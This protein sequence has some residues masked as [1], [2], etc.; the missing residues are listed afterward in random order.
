MRTPEVRTPDPTAVF[1]MFHYIRHN[2]R[3]QEHLA[4]LGLDLAQRRVL[5]LGAGIGDH[6]TFFLDRG[7][8][9]VAVEPR[10]ENVAFFRA[11]IASARY[12]GEVPLTI[13]AMDVE[14]AAKKLRS[15]RFDV[16]Y[17]YGLLYHVPDPLP[18][19]EFAREVCTSLLLLETC[20]SFG[21]HEAVNNVPEQ[22]GDVTQAVA[23]MGCRPTRPW[24][25]RRL[26]EL[27]EYAYMPV[28]QPWHEEFP[29]DWTVPPPPAGRLTR[30]VFVASRAPL[31]NPLLVA[32]VPDRQSRC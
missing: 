26:S 31:E 28:T 22:A 12:A 1:R 14:T 29:L 9:V 32:H 23:G 10:P 30:A 6:S 24:I 4:T 2:Q 8:T 15:E 25:Y 27:F 20:V 16:V 18:V 3:R 11:S 7:S 19:L 21:T 13:H 17:C 5:E